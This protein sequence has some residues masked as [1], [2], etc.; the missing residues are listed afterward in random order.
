MYD[1]VFC[2]SCGNVE[3][4]P[5]N[6]MN[7]KVVQTCSHCIY[8]YDMSLSS[9]KSKMKSNVLGSLVSNNVFK[10]IMKTKW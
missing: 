7:R 10:P 3:F 6:T 1:T 8:D 4:E 9:N 2:M 5:S